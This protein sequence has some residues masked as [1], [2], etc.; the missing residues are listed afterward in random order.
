MEKAGEILKRLSVPPKQGGSANAV[1]LS[2]LQN[3]ARELKP[4]T[5]AHEKLLNAGLEII[6][7]PNAVELAFLA[8]E[9]V[10][11]TLPHSDPGD[12]P[13]WSRTNGNL[14]LVVARA[15]MDR[16]TLKPIGYPFGSLPRLLLFWMNTEA[17]RT[18]KRRLDLGD[19]FS[20]FIRELGLD[21]S[22]GGPCSDYR[23]VREQMRRLFSSAITFQHYVEINGRERDSQVDMKVTAASELWWDPKR[24]DQVSLWGSWLELGEK[25][26]Q[27]ITLAPVPTD[28]RALRALKRSPLAL[29]LYIWSAH[30]AYS[31]A[32]KNKAQ[33]VP[34][35][36]L[37]RQFGADYKDPK[38]F[39]K[40]AI[41]ALTKIQAVYPGLKLQDAPGGIVV[42]SSSRPAVPPKGLTS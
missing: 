21:S 41:G 20:N 17:V 34:W 33:F 2:L 31:A 24:P 5:R 42:L 26:F 12:V 29:D 19:T 37:A 9:L 1:Q 13:L 22:R 3:P 4:V 36:T 18:G 38:N 14:T 27:A 32:A 6:Q 7:A 28:L 25:F 35:T 23:R 39:R 16:R 8:R 40:K 30:K 15:G 11:C 10:H